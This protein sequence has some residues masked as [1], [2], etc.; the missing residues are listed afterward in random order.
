MTRMSRYASCV[1]NQKPSNFAG[2]RFWHAVCN[3]NQRTRHTNRTTEREVMRPSNPKSSTAGIIGAL[4]T[5]YLAERD[6]GICAWCGQYA[7]E[8]DPRDECCVEDKHAMPSELTCRQARYKRAIANT[9]SL[10]RGEIELKDVDKLEGVVW[11]DED[12]TPTWKLLI[13]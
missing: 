3:G 5:Y 1:P 6:D 2:L 9:Q 13:D 10:Q 11:P 8:L 4:D 12:G 7:T